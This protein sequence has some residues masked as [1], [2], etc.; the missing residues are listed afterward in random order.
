M[1]NNLSNSSPY[2]LPIRRDLTSAYILSLIVAL[3]VTA[4][5]VRGWFFPSTIYPT[6]ELRQSFM[7]NDVVNIFVG[8]PILLGSMWLTRRGKL[9]GLLFWPGALLYHLYNYIAY[10][11]GI[12][13]GWATF[14][15]LALVLLSA[16]IVFDLL[17]NIDQETVQELLSGAVPEKFSGWVLVV[18]GIAFF[19][20][21]IGIIAEA[22]SSSTMLPISEIGVLIADLV[23]SI[24]WVGGGVLLLRRR[25]LGY[26]SGLGSLFA[27]SALFIGLILFL[28]LRPVL[29]NYPFDLVEVITVSIMGLVC[30]I[31]FGLFVR[32][33]ASK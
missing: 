25:A 20:R 13:F 4:A 28:L 3:L 11:F 24:V 21:A 7:P 27:A 31:P 22:S 2:S 12:P 14:A 26:A 33:V 17:K 30:F 10:V 9:L 5:S 18:F 15:N 32:A 16:Y 19:F 6:E 23:I 29:T 1:K 8:L